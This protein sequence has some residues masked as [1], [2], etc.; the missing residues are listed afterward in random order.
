VLRKVE[1]VYVLLTI[2]QAAEKLIS[3]VTQQSEN[4]VPGKKNI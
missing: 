1:L 3:N 2:P 4:P